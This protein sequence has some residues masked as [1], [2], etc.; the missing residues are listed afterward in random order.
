MPDG[1]LG[2]GVMWLT[3]GRAGAWGR[4]RRGHSLRCSVLW[5]RSAVALL[6]AGHRGAAIA[7][8]AAR[9]GRRAIAPRHRGVGGRLRH[10]H[11][12]GAA[13]QQRLR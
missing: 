10:G 7:R 13:I 1:L 8:G 2:N 3:C 5:G 11:S 4:G 6:L 9:G 12:A